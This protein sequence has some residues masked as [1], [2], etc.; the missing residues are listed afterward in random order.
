MDKVSL[1][2]I[3]LSEE[4]RKII[5]EINHVAVHASDLDGIA[6]AALILLMKPTAKI[7]FLTVAEAK[8][9]RNSYD[10]VID[11]PKIGDAINIDHHKTNYDRLVAEARLSEIDLVDPEAPSAALL[12]A[13]YFGILGNKHVKN[14]VNIATKSDLGKFDDKIYVIDKIIKCNSR[15]KEALYRIAWAVA[16][17]GKDF[18]KDEW[19]R[20]EIERIKKVFDEC[21]RISRFVVDILLRKHKAKA[22]VLH[23]ESSVPRICIGDVMHRYIESGGK[24]I[25]LINTMREKDKY[26]PSLTQNMGQPYARISIRS[27]DKNFD[28]RKFLEQFGGGG[29][30]VAAGARISI[31]NLHEFFLF[32]FRELSNYSRYVVYFKIN[33][34][35]LE[36]MGQ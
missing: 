2:R 25:V 3:K 5:D 14:I 34:E 35:A 32:V 17:H 7:D 13:K 9:C 30:K 8:N 33:K 4:H 11:L 12:V 10:L 26:C 29:H 31:D 21:D 15:D 19:L 18:E 23:V 6:S 16:I 28:A 27:R 20:S 1:P 24:I 22:V 36:S